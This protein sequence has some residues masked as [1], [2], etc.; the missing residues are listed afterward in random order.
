MTG[1]QGTGCPRTTADAV[2]APPMTLSRDRQLRLDWLRRAVVTDPTALIA[3]ALKR[4]EGTGKR[5]YGDTWQHRT[6]GALLG[7]VREECADILGW[8][9]LIAQR[10]LEHT[11]HPAAANID[12]LIAAAC[13]H[14]AHADE[15]L[16]EAQRLA[17]ELPGQRAG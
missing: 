17:A 1:C 3:H 8:S 16:A 13:E 10:L 5:S 15:L 4:I 12:A 7:E 9:S 6:I 14:A 11:E 2:A